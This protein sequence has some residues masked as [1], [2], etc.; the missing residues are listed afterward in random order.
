M[1]PL[2]CFFM[3]LSIG[4]AA[5]KESGKMYNFESLW[6]PDTPQALSFYQICS[7]CSRGGMKCSIKQKRLKKAV[8]S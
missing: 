2:Y 4:D 3:R 6:M 8:T 7:M 1:H 5:E